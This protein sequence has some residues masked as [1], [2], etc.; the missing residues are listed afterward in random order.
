MI[1]SAIFKAHCNTKF[2]SDL[3]IN[4]MKIGALA[5]LKS[6]NKHPSKVTVRIY[7]KKCFYMLVRDK[8]CSLNFIRG[9]QYPSNRE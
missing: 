6:G 2:P 8:S 1:P 3:K 7:F 9:P 5:K 4:T